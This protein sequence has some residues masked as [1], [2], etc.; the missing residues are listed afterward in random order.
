MA[1]ASQIED[2]SPLQ[3]YCRLKDAGAIHFVDEDGQPLTFALAFD[4]RC[5][6]HM[7]NAEDGEIYVQELAHGRDILARHYMEK[8][9][10]YV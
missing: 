1:P 9:G 4:R 10:A 5:W 7:R 8:M 6:A 3:W 2:L